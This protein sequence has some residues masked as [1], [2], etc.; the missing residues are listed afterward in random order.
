[1]KKEQETNYLDKIPSVN[2]ESWVEGEDGN[3]IL[4]VKHKGIVI[5]VVAWLFKR[6]RISNIP[7]DEISSK[8]WRLIDGKRTIQEIGNIM[9]QQLGEQV[10]PVYERLSLLIKY[11]SSQGWIT[12]K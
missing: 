3:I 11:L 4:H 6:S 5:A 7:L 2:L 9:D 1:M 8:A 10:A 12:L